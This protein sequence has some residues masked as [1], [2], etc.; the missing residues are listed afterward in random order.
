M[1]A[2]GPPP[3]IVPFPRCDS[4]GD[5]EPRLLLSERPGKIVLAI[6]AIIL[7][8]TADNLR[9]MQKY[10]ELSGVDGLVFDVMI[11][12][13][14]TLHLSHVITWLI[15]STQQADAIISVQKTE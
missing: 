1:E 6:P 4:G 8:A 12:L 13:I 9:G 11:L 10:D 15:P 2:N 3:G 14:R 5:D 7:M